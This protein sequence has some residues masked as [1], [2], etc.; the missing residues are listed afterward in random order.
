ME[1]TGQLHARAALPPR[2]RATDIHWI[3]GWVDPRAILD[4]VVK[5]KILNRRWELNPKTPIDQFLAYYLLKYM[6]M[7]Y[8]HI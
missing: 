8:R 3:R 1:L 7:V 2:E 6:F 5:R 4:A